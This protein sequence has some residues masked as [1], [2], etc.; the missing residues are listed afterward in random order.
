MRLWPCLIA[1]IASCL[2]LT[3]PASAAPVQQPH[4]QLELVAQGEAPPGGE[5][6]VALRQKIDPDWHTF[7]R[8]PG[9]AGEATRLVWTLPQGWKAGEFV[10]P[11]PERYPL[12]PLVN[13]VYTGEVLL[14][15]PI[16]VPANARPGETVT[17]TAQAVYQVC[18]DQCIPGQAALSLDV[19]VAAGQPVT[20]PRWFE[21]IAKVVAAAPKGGMLEA[22]S[23]LRDGTLRIGVVGEAL[24]GAD[25]SKAYFF[26]FSQLLIDHAKPQRVERGPDGLTMILTPAP[27]VPGG[28]EPS[29]MG[30]LSLGERAFEIVAPPGQAP[31]GSAGGGM[32]ATAMEGGGPDPPLWQAIAFA[33]LGGLILNLMPCVFP[34]LSMKAASLAL[35]AHEAR[36]ARG[37][38]L[39]FLAG[40]VV[41]FLVLAGALIA[42]KAAGSAVGWGFHLQSPAVVAV[43]TML[44][45]LIALNLSG[46][47]E[48][49]L[50]AQGVGSGLAARGGLAGAFFTG[51]LAVVVAAP[52]TA[53]FM[54][55]ALGYALAQ[56]AAVA[57]GVFAALGLGFALPFTALA[58]APGLLRRMPRPGPW[59]DI[60]KTVLAFP[61]Y[62]AAAWLVW[63]FTAQAGIAAL[64]FLL[65]AGLLIAFGAWLFGLGQASFET[66]RKLVLQAALP[67]ALVA[68][69]LILAP[70]ARSTAAQAPAEGE[71]K[72]AISYEA[73][74]PERLAELRAEGKPVFVNFTAAWCVSCQANEI[75][76]LSNRSVAD[77]FQ[78]HGVTYLKGDW[79]NRDAVI[80]KVLAEHGQA[81]VPLYLVYP[82]GGGEPQKL[83]QL[84][85]PGIVKT[86]LEKA[87]A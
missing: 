24:K 71:A 74:T 45:L 67:L 17:L 55:V 84:L 81:G 14:P 39:A 78:A 9:D 25:L 79:T 15:V 36:T 87:A 50:S 57:L 59:M 19:K 38:G 4:V 69:A 70:V 56:P 2:A 3:G 52:C 35:H 53:P 68:A 66:R 41:T 47:F 11:V 34:V 8:N 75:T 80:A 58:F 16:A 42:A 51:A 86:A 82:K 40:C 76:S 61:M 31:A 23:E 13:Y 6:Y 12:G 20:D 64:P 46:V 28:P 49:G 60:F 18:S 62:G 21:P 32:V 63:V 7:W 27:P 10:W 48:I 1:A 30:V 44:M 22:A 83:P 37:Q 26:P 72:A 43:L 5:L 29:Y 65:G 73:F 77:A 54:G 85:T 33:F